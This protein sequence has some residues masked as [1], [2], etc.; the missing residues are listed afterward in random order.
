MTTVRYIW[1]AEIIW[2]VVRL[3]PDG[4]EQDFEIVD[5][6]EKAKARAAKMDKKAREG[7][8]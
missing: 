8:E 7:N 6:E 4:T 5:S 1:R 3:D 2:K